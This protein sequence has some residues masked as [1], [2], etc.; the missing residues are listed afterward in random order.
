MTRLQVVVLAAVALVAAMV[1]L[2]VG[3]GPAMVVAGIV[4]AACPGVALGWLLARAAS[5]S[6]VERWVASAAASLAVC[7]LG[8]FVLNV[9]GGL[10]PAS[11]VGLL[12]G[13]TALGAGVALVRGPAPADRGSRGA[14]PVGRRWSGEP[15]R[16][17]V[18]GLGALAIAGAA[19]GLSVS[20]D[21]GRPAP[22]F[23][24][25]WVVPHVARGAPTGTAQVG[26]AD[27]GRAPTRFWLVVSADGAPTSS[28][29]FTL[30]PGQSRT[31]VVPVSGSEHLG[32]TLYRAVGHTWPATPYRQ[33]HC[34]PGASWRSPG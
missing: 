13:V 15:A 17:A 8:A 2:V 7:A 22:G 18:L 4:G 14:R 12:T 28:W 31:W 30:S 19:L 32:A 16:V 34:V 10:T 21:L 25:L 9:V 20:S 3:G 1:V 6:A 11:W 29:T 26:V 5:L 24:A 23:A 33:V 27:Q